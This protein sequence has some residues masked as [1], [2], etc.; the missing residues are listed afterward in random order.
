MMADYRPGVIAGAYPDDVEVLGVEVE[1][2]FSLAVEAFE[3]ARLWF[4]IL[5]LIIAAAVVGGMDR[6][7]SQH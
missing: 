1:A 3:E 2:D 4:A 6:K 5:S 7:R